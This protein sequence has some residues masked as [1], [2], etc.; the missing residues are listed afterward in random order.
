MR[1]EGLLLE[2]YLLNNPTSVH[3]QSEG[4]NVALHRTRK[5]SL[6]HLSSMFEHFL[7]HL[8]F[9]GQKVESSAPIKTYI[10]PEDILD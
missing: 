10:V 7:N 6:L 4:K 2:R 8:A 1:V 9:L 5:N 3:L